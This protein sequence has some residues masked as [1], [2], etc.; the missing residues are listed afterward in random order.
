MRASRRK[1]LGLVSVITIGLCG[2]AP[3]ASADN[4]LQGMQFKYLGAAGWEIQSD[5]VVILID[6]YI[7]RINY[8]GHDLGDGRRIYKK[9]DY[10]A[11]DTSLIDQIITRADYILIHHSH[12]DH[13]LDVPYIAKKTGAKVLATETANSILR[14]FGVSGEQLYT[15]MGGEDYEFGNL[16][17]RA[18]PSLHSAL[19]AKQYFSPERYHDGVKSPLTIEEFIEGGSLMFLVRVGGREV[20]TMGSMNFIERELQGLRPD[21]LLAGAGS[22]RHEIYDY[23]RRLL[24]AT[25]F[26][27]VVMPTH[28]DNF[29]VAYDNE[30]A[31]AKARIDKADPFVVEVR[32]ASPQ[33]RVIVPK[34]LEPIGIED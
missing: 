4:R 10:P 33:S 32:A 26:P 27:R 23:T 30:A 24:A 16:S 29:S 5:G 18:V 11:S 20:L 21:V 2:L 17:I 15:L 1:I 8:T 7:S 6:P 13:I 28:W 25:G 22:S 14:A 9:S 34:H 3:F 19:S 31:L 12:F